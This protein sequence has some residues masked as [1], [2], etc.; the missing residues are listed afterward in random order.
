MA[1]SLEEMPEIFGRRGVNG[2]RRNGTQLREEAG[3]LF[4]RRRELRI[5]FGIFCGEMR[6]AA[7]GLRDI[8]IEKQRL[9]VGARCEDARIG[10]KNLAIEFF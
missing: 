7:G 10:A 8:V 4:E 9:A 2:G 5:F 1:A 3:D 6:D